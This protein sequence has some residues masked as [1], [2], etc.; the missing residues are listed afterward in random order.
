MAAL[1]GD[2][3]PRLRAKIGSSL[4]SNWRKNNHAQHRTL[5]P[6]SR[7]PA[8]ES[9][10]RVPRGGCARE[11]A[12]AQ[13]L[14]LYRAS[15]GTEGRRHFKMSFRNFTTGQA[16]AFGGKYIELVPHERVRYTD[17]FDDPNLPGEIQVTVTLKQVSSAPKSTSCRKACPTSFRR[18]L[19]IWVGRTL[20]ETWHASSSPKSIHRAI[21]AKPPPARA[22]GKQIY[23][24]M[25]ANTPGHDLA[26]E[27]E[28]YA[29]WKMSS[30][31]RTRLP[32]SSMRCEG[33][34][35]TPHWSLRP[36]GQVQSSG[37]RTL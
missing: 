17:K 21:A 11:M 34:V 23:A 4:T 16:H 22:L 28:P 13:R 33:P 15:F 30:A 6:R 14:R 5:A 32:A 36:L 35:L 12:S 27:A 1:R 3:R 25:K 24:I 31:K 7:D 26:S 2:P 37:P 8:R 10:P 9:L 29:G 20:C 18:K 19:A